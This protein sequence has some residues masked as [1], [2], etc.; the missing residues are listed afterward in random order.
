MN[1]LPFGDQDGLNHAKRSIGQA[2]NNIESRR[3]EGVKNLFFDATTLMGL[4]SAAHKDHLVAEIEQLRKDLEATW[5]TEST[6]II[7][8]DLDRKLQSIEILQRVTENLRASVTRSI[9][10]TED[11]YPVIFSLPNWTK[12]LSANFKPQYLLSDMSIIRDQPFQSE[13]LSR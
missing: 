10:D 5:L 2:R 12:H 3:T 4:V 9:D 6:R 7:T 8:G 13:K 1:I 11:V